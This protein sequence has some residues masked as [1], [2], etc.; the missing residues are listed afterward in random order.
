[1]KI[2]EKEMLEVDWSTIHV[3]VHKHSGQS[4]HFKGWEFEILKNC[5]RVGVHIFPLKRVD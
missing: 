2:P 1:M 5:K 4:M 3:M